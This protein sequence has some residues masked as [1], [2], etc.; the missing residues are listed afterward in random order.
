MNEYELKP[1]PFCGNHNLNIR[2]HLGINGT[3]EVECSNCKMKFEYEEEYEEEILTNPLH[4][5]VEIHTRLY[6]KTKPTFIEAWNR[7]EDNDR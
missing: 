4:P 3:V 6:E 7:R 1:C 2:T 5:N